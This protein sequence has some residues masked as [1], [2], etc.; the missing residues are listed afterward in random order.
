MMRVALVTIRYHR[1]SVPKTA[2]PDTGAVFT[3][4]LIK[5]LPT[6]FLKEHLPRL[7]STGIKDVR[8]KV[9]DVNESLSQITRV[10]IAATIAKTAAK[11]RKVSPK[12]Q[13]A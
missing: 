13:S 6:T 7:D 4:S 12:R 9:L 5:A 10:P 1:K 8:A 11:T 2:E 3:C